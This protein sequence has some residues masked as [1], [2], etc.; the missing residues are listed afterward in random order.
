[1]IVNKIVSRISFRGSKFLVKNNRFVRFN[2]S[3]TKDIVLQK[4]RDKLNEKANALGLKDVDDLKEKL[5]DDI[6]KKKKE[7]SAID[8]LKELEEYERRQALEISKNDDKT[9]KVRSPIDKNK[10]QAPYKV[11]DSFVDV[12][13]LK[14]LP[15]KELEFIWRARF[16]NIERTMV[17][18]LNNLQFAS[19]YANAF[20]NPSFILP[21]AKNEDGYEMHFVQWSFIGPKTTHCMLTTVAEYKLHKEYAKPHTTLMFHQELSNSKDVVLMNGQVEEESSLTMDEAQLLVL[22]VQRFYGGIA[23]AKGNE[24]KLALLRDFTS[25]NADFNMEEL[26]AEAA[27]ID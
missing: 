7:F 24:K 6:E 23:S 2:S 12:E 27:S 5:K 22:N 16:Q 18:V 21:L 14:D 20:K 11:L 17:A 15:L 25:G 19:M 9:I 3:N 10:P 8:P 4:Y 13:K 1:M 26:I